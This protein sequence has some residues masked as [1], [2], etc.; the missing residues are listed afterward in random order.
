MAALV[1]YYNKIGYCK[2]QEMCRNLH[3]NEICE[4]FLCDVVSCDKRHPR[5]CKYYMEYKRCKF[6]PCAYL[7]VEES[8]KTVKYIQNVKRKL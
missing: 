1:C 7:H 4:N 3:I 6:N 8:D 5:K 2:H